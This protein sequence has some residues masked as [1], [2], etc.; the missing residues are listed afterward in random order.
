MPTTS[1]G[2]FS[3][4]VANDNACFH[5]HLGNHPVREDDTP[6]LTTPQLASQVSELKETVSS[7]RDEVFKLSCAF[8]KHVLKEEEEEHYSDDE[9]EFEDDELEEPIPDYET[10][11]HFVENT[12]ETPTGKRSDHF[13]QQNPGTKLEREKP[14][15]LP[16]YLIESKSDS[17]GLARI[18]GKEHTVEEFVELMKDLN[19][20][21]ANWMELIS[22]QNKQDTAKETQDFLKNHTRIP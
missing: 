22:Y 21:W 5:F 19:T 2:P 14:S 12:W 7:L 20:L 15:T 18:G 11:E 16:A 9:Y 6:R 10:G 8:E 4:L 17:R 3:T 13:G 1:G